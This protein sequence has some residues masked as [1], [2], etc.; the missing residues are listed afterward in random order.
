[1]SADGI[2][3]TIN[4]EENLDQSNAFEDTKIIEDSGSESGNNF[5]MQRDDAS[6]GRGTIL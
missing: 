6:S 3:T 1:M 2:N 4:E 5:I